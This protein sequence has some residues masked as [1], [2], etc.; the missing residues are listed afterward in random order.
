MHAIPSAPPPSTPKSYSFSYSF[1][2][3]KSPRVHRVQARLLPLMI[4]SNQPACGFRHLTPYDFRHRDL[5]DRCFRGRDGPLGR[6]RHSQVCHRSRDRQPAVGPAVT[7]YLSLPRNRSR[8]HTRSRSRKTDIHPV[9][10]TRQT[11]RPCSSTAQRAPVLVT[12]LGHVLTAAP[13]T[14]CALRQTFDR[15]NAPPP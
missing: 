12:P 13:S 8:S 2:I 11:F 1:S 3:S 7:P 15:R 6:P 14:R 4:R 5:S 10:S 9:I